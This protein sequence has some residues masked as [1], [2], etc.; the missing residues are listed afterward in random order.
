MHGFEIIFMIEPDAP[1]ML[2]CS[3]LLTFEVGTR[4]EVPLDEVTYN[5]GCVTA[6]IFMHSLSVL[7]YNILTLKIT[8]I[9][10]SFIY[11]VL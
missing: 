5:S 8:I 9:F 11:Y 1:F 6:I 4:S 10:V 7:L 3:T 2:K